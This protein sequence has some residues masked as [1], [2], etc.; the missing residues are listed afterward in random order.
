MFPQRP[1]DTVNLGLGDVEARRGPGPMSRASCAPS[2]PNDVQVFTRPELEGRRS[3]FDDAEP[4]RADFRVR[5]D[6]RL[7]SSGIMVLYQ[8]LATQIAR[9][10]AAIRYLKAIGY[11]NRFLDGS[12]SSKRAAHVDRLFSG[13]R[14][15]ARASTR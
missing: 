3:P 8:T 14:R 10:L 13:A 7:R 9:Q 1:P 15:G 12:F 4:D 2:C 5:A 11:T 6:R